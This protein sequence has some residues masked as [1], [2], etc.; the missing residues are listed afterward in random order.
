VHDGDD[1]YLAVA[2]REARPA[3]GT[4]FAAGRGG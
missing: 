1:R 4:R 3:T 2:R